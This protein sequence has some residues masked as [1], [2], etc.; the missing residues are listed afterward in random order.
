MLVDEYG[1]EPLMAMLVETV[2]QKEDEEKQVK[3]EKV[4]TI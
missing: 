1:V 4:I 3:F 2:G